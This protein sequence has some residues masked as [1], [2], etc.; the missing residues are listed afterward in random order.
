MET[1]DHKNND[2]EF[3]TES[4]HGLL[5]DTEGLKNVKHTETAQPIIIKVARSPLLKT[6]NESAALSNIFKLS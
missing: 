3:R 4:V 6:F 2:E 1:E 5:L